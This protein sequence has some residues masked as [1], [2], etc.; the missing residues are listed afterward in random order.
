IASSNPAVALVSPNATT[1][2]TSFIDVVVPNLSIA[3]SFVVHG[4]ENVT[5]TSN[6]TA[7]ATG[8]TGTSQIATI[9]Q[10]AVDISGLGSAFDVADANDPFQL[11]V[12]LPTGSNGS[13]NPLQVVRAGSSGLTATLILSSSTPG[14]L[15]TTSSTNDTV[16]VSIPVGASASAATVAA[17]GVAFDPLAIGTTLVTATI[18]GFI[19]TGAATQQV[20][21]SSH[22]IT[23]ASIDNV[24]A[25]LQTGPVT[26]TLGLAQHGG[27]TVH[28]ASSDPS[29]ALVAPNFSTPGSASLDFPLSNGST[30]VSFYVQGIAAGASTI[31]ASVPAFVS[32]VRTANVV[33]PALQVALLADTLLD[34]AANDPFVVQVGV[35]TGDN[36]ALATAQFVRAGGATLTATLTSTGAIVAPLVKGSQSGSP[37]TVDIPAGA[38]QSAASASL[39]G[40]EV[41]P[42]APGG[43][44]VSA[45]IPGFIATTAA[46]HAVYIKPHAP[47]TGATPLP[48]A[49]ALEQNIPNPFNPLTHIRFTLPDPAHVNLSVFDVRGALV[50]T[51]L[52]ADMPRGAHDELWNGHDARGESVGSGVYFYRLTTVHHV[53]TRKMVLLK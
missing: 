12:G 52:D 40:V 24:G 29:I 15:V 32:G 42:V 46:S 35:P 53:L 3:A 7:S 22:T 38:L 9:V 10:P 50:I 21:V 49:L 8:F 39:G 26:A 31:T 16:T 11:R 20:V 25:G 27:V 47:P 43:T 30:Q 2:G 4:R 28:V 17:G 19:T 5:G 14:Q 34:D 45:S 6:I 44:I 1:A 23:M 13:V 48:L 33:Q 18:P 41:D 37:V 36:A 51:L